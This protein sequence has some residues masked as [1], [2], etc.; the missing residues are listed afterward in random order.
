MTD[1]NELPGA[2]QPA[3]E[4]YLAMSASKDAYFNFMVELDQKYKQ[5]G[6]ASI[7]ENLK[8]EQL[9]KA[10]DEKVTAFNEAMQASMKELDDTGRNALIRA[11]GGNVMSH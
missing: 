3:Y 6:E 11:M 7:A 8:L 10:H 4:A 9:L 2:A 5:G 1:N